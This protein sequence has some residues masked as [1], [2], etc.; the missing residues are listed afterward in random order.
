MVRKTTVIK[1]PVT[2][3]TI[4]ISIKT[5]HFIIVYVTFF[6]HVEFLSVQN[7]N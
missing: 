1:Q 4:K 5:S 7:N 2:Y 3:P 6:F